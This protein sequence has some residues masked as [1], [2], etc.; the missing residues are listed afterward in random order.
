MAIAWKRTRHNFIIIIIIYHTI[1]DIINATD[2]SNRSSKLSAGESFLWKSR[3]FCIHY[4]LHFSFFVDIDDVFFLSTSPHVALLIFLC[5]H[6]T[7]AICLLPSIIQKA[8]KNVFSLVFFAEYV[9][10][11][12]QIF[13]SA[14]KIIPSS[15]VNN[16][17]CVEILF[18]DSG[19][20]F[21][22]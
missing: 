4:R 3:K 16:P 14:V 18:E 8:F 5:H 10:V 17:L 21:C 7:H 20:S 11:V 9:Y 12:D 1:F 6:A 2:C 15:E 22:V 19:I 13:P